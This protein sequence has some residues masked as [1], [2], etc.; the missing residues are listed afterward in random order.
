M[1]AY[2]NKDVH[3]L[4]QGARQYRKL[5]GELRGPEYTFMTEK[6]ERKFCAGDRIIFLRNEHSL[7]V[8]NGSLGTVENINRRESW[9]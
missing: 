1:M 9:Q 8:R 6:G 3:D 4:N 2:T 7:G 5:H